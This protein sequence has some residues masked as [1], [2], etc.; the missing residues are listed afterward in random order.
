M[1]ANRSPAAR[2]AA[3]SAR[4]RTP[5]RRRGARAAAHAR[6]RRAQPREHVAPLRI[7]EGG[8]AARTL[9]R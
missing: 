7:G 8:C 5:W 2:A 1:P 3:S 9:R 6:T 4:P